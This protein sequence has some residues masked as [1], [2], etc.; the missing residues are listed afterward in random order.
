[1]GFMLPSKPV[2]QQFPTMPSQGVSRDQQTDM[3]LHPAAQSITSH[4]KPCRIIEQS[5][6]SIINK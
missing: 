2:T 1:M 6:K 4:G 3:F 5:L